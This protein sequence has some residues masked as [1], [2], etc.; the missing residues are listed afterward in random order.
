MIKVE[1][2]LERYNLEQANVRS[3][4][5]RMQAEYPGKN[6]EPEI[7]PE[8]SCSERVV[9]IEKLYVR[10][11]ERN[12]DKLQDLLLERDY[13]RMKK[14]FQNILKDDD[15]DDPEELAGTIHGEIERGIINSYTKV[16]QDQVKRLEQYVLDAGYQKAEIK[17]GDDLK[18]NTKYFRKTF[19]ETTK[20]SN[21][22]NLIKEVIRPPYILRYDNAG[23]TEELILGGECIYYSYKRE[24]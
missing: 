24:G 12:L 13:Q 16:K 21:Q 14:E 19:P 2:L 4:I 6:E 17:P 22:R 8:E 1:A 7:V 20:K 23:D 15:Y 9:K 5:I 3:F 10:L 18:K 11:L